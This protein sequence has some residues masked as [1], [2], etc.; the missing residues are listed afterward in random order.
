MC[1]CTTKHPRCAMLWYATH[2]GATIPQG[3]WRSGADRRELQQLYAPPPAVVRRKTG[4]VRDPSG[5]VLFDDISTQ[6]GRGRRR[7]REPSRQDCRS[8]GVSVSDLPAPWRA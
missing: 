4:F 8:L 1:T 7:A 3:A 2:L 6:S 5:G